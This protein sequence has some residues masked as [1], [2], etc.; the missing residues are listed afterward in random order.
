MSDHD[1]LTPETDDQLRARLRAFAEEVEE[2]TDTEAALERMP[3]RSRPPTIRLLAIAACFVL[4]VAVAAAVMAD[5]QSVDTV[6]PAESPTTDCPTPAQPRAITQGAQM[7]NRFAAPVASAATTLVLLGACSDDGPTTVAKGDDIEMVG[8]DGFAGQ[9]LNVDAE[10]EDGEVTGEFRVTDNV[11]TVECADTD[12]DGVVILGGA[13][14]AGPDLAEGDLIALIIREGDPDSV[15]LM[16]NDSN[17]ASCTEMLDAIPG[18][19]QTDG[20]E[21]VDVEPGDDIETG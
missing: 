18:E 7:K 21:F 1:T 9:T 4:V 16:A 3:S 6:P 11:I 13:V 20:P 10:E 14:A 5:R 12:T 8:E 2:R 17:A 15:A 19:G